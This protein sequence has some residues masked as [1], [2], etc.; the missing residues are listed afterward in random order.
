MKKT[1]VFSTVGL[2]VVNALTWMV[3]SRYHTFN[4]LASSVV[5]FITGCFNYTAAV[6]PLKDAYRVAH[7]FLFSLLGVALFLLI[8]FSPHQLKDNWCVVAALAT[9]LFEAIALYITH[10]ISQNNK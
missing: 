9:M 4:M 1:I 8:L 6:I 3:I 5:L 10:I 7:Y 2:I